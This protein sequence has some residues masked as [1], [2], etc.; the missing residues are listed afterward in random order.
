M[1][2]E[3]SK[4]I[5]ISQI[6]P[7]NK[8]INSYSLQIQSKNLKKFMKKQ[9]SLFESSSSNN[10]DCSSGPYYEMS[11]KSNNIGDIFKREIINIQYQNQNVDGN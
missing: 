11:E 1:Q 9:G 4:Q 3:E 2:I 6:K 5:G 8:N 10:E 7:L